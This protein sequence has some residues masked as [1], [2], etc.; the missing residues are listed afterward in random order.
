[1]TTPANQSETLDIGGMTVPTFVPPLVTAALTVVFMLMPWVHVPLAETA[2]MA[3][4]LVG[5]GIAIASDY[6]VLRLSDL[7]AIVPVDEYSKDGIAA[8]RGYVFFWGASI[9]VLVAGAILYITGKNWLLIVGC[10][11]AAIAAIVWCGVMVYVQ[12]LIA[13]EANGIQVFTLPPWPIATIIASIATLVFA[14]KLKDPSVVANAPAGQTRPIPNQSRSGVTQPLTPPVSS[15]QPLTPPVVTPP[16]STAPTAY[17]DAS[18]FCPNC[19]AQ[20]QIAAPASHCII[21]ITCGGCG[22]KF[23]MEVRPRS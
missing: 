21:S 9:A 12:D 22:A 10:V 19:G 3:G 17:V 1:M 20:V 6:T 16:T 23:P 8:V 5:Q 14:V 11:M 18:C 4:A 2:N 13:E 15:T 7:I